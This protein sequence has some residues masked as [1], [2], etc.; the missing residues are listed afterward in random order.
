MSDIK[1]PKQR[2][3]ITGNRYHIIIVVALILALHLGMSTGGLAGATIVPYD[4]GDREDIPSAAARICNLRCSRVPGGCAY[5]FDLEVLETSW[6]PVYALEIETLMDALLEPIAWPEGWK[7]GTVPSGPTGPGSMVFYTVDQPI[8][9]GSV[10]TGFG[11]MSYS[12]GSA[13]RWFPADEDGIL[14]GK[15]SRIDLS[16][17]VATEPR[18]LCSIKAIYR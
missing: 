10:R 13:I 1:M 14:V 11:L 6:A 16:C 2:S 4:E 3:P 12:G 5:T 15:V 7:A 18:S 9:P 8:L 17:P